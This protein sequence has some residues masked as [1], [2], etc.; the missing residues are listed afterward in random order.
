MCPAKP[1]PRRPTRRKP[2]RTHPRAKRWAFVLALALGATALVTLIVGV[3]LYKTV[4]TFDGDEVKELSVM[5]SAIG[6]ALVAVIKLWEYVI[7]HT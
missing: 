5:A 6:P 3:F 2:T 4:N 1:L 7:N